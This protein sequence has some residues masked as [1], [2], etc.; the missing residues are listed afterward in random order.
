MFKHILCLQHNQAQTSSMYLKHFLYICQ[1]SSPD[2]PPP[3]MIFNTMHQKRNAASLLHAQGPRRKN[4]PTTKKQQ[5]EASRLQ[6]SPHTNPILN[7][8]YGQTSEFRS[9][10]LAFSFSIC[11]PPKSHTG[12]K[13]NSFV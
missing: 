2:I 5:R 9:Q 8:E 1:K 6:H 7:F 12:T 4:K 13:S 10:G 11:H 3:N